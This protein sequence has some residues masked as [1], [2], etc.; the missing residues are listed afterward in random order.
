MLS[1]RLHAYLVTAATIVHVSAST[2]AHDQAKSGINALPGEVGLRVRGLSRAGV[3]ILVVQEAETRVL[4][5]RADAALEL[6]AL[7]ATSLG[8]VCLGNDVLG[9]VVLDRDDSGSVGE[10]GTEEVV[11]CA[12][13]VDLLGGGGVDGDGGRGQGDGLECDCGRHDLS[14]V[15]CLGTHGP[16]R[17]G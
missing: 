7:R 3:G 4:K 5:G 16:R 15:D 13:C 1:L 9:R 2:V 11:G 14:A 17:E 12:G 8:R 6:H 10:T